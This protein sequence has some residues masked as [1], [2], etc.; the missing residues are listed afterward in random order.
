MW[1]ISN[2]S[3]ST[4]TLVPNAPSGAEVYVSREDAERFIEE[5]RGDEPDLAKHLPGTGATPE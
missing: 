2:S 1:P 5:V 3:K 4:P